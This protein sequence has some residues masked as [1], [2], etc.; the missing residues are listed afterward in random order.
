MKKLFLACLLVPAAARAEE[1]IGLDLFAPRASVSVQ[2]GPTKDFKD[3]PGTFREHGWSA[4]ASVPLTGRAAS[5]SDG[6]TGHQLLARAAFGVA[7]PDVSF[8]NRQPTLYSGAL[9]LTE[10][11]LRPSKNFLLFSAG[12]SFAEDDKTIQHMS[13]RFTGMG[14]ASYRTE[15]KLIFLYG[16]GYSYGF[17]RGLL[18]PVLGLQWRTEGP[19]SGSVLLPFSVKVRYRVNQ[20]FRWGL[21][22]GASG[23]RYRFS[24]EGS[25]PG[26]S[27]TLRLRL[28]QGRAGFDADYRLSKGL[29]LAGELGVLAGRRFAISD[30]NTDLVASGIQPSGYLKLSVRQS[31]GKSALQAK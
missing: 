10:I 2:G 20:D 24:N 7:S 14:L 25:F 26:A 12:A 21:L 11:L 17:G 18:L 4:D 30:G 27:E 3:V 23:D 28:T 31:F 15:S 9:G 6:A 13:P 8:L 19:W 1:M 5:D 29:S 22:V 16:L